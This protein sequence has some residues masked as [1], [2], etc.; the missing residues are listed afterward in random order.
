VISH[1]P[2]SYSGSADRTVKFWDL[3]TFELIGSTRPEAT[4][5]RS[6]K[7][8]PDGRTLFCGLDD[9]LKVL[10]FFVMSFTI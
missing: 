9:S 10:I 1:S 5:V 2:Y 4:G 7:F 6:I 8:H 3:E